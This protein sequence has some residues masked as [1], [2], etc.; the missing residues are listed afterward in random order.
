[1]DFTDAQKAVLKHLFE[2]GDNLPANIAEDTDYHRN[3]LTNQIRELAEAGLV[4]NKGRGV[5]TLTPAGRNAVRQ[6]QE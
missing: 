6:F 3:Y 2:K 4:R 5:W 1:M